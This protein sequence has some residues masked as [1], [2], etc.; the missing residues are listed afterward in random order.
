MQSSSLSSIQTLLD[1]RNQT[2]GIILTEVVRQ[3]GEALHADRCFICV[4][5]PHKQRCQI[6]FVWRRDDSIPAVA[7]GMEWNDESNITDKEPLYMAALAC[8][9]SVYVTD[10]KTATPDVLNHD[11]EARYLGHRALIHGHIVQDGQLWGT[12]QPCVFGQPCEWTEADRT[13]IETLLPL[14]ADPIKEFIQNE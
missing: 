6:A 3:I 11:F 13:F 10:V 12:L 14:L 4:R 9:P 8:R 2:P 7:F 5:D 1:S